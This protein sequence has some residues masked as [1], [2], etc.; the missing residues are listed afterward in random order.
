M[1]IPSVVACKNKE[2]EDTIKQVSACSQTTSLVEDERSECNNNMTKKE[3][4]TMETDDNQ[5]KRINK[6]QQ[7]KLLHARRDDNDKTVNLSDYRLQTHSKSALYP[8]SRFS[9]SQKCGPSS[10]EVEVEILV[11]RECLY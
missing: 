6:K 10:Y 9:G 8:G 7:K 5:R 3:D 1:P 4:E 2:D 11:N